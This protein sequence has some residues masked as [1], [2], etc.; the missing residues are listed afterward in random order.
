MLMGKHPFRE[1]NMANVILSN[2]AMFEEI[3]K[4]R[5]E[6]KILTSNLIIMEYEGQIVTVEVHFKFKY[7]AFSLVCEYKKIYYIK[8]EFRSF[9]VKL[10]FS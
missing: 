9:D 2:T 6:N 8:M 7:L 5:N 3:I 4:K 10:I 1:M